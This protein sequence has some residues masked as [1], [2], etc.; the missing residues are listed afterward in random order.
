MK[1]TLPGGASR[2]P[3]AIYQ[4]CLERQEVRVDPHQQRVVDQLDDLWRALESKRA[5]GLFSAWRRRARVQGIYLWGG[6]GRGK[7]WLMDLFLESLSTTR[8]RRAHFHRFMA[9]VHQ[10]LNQ[11]SNARDPLSLIARQWSDDCDVLCFDE[12]YVSDI[13]D[14]M[15]LGNLLEKLFA[16]G[17]VLVAT[18]N[19]RPDDLYRG[20]LQRSRFLPA[21]ECI[22]QHCRVIELPG[23]RD[24]RLRLLERAGVYQIRESQDRSRAMSHRFEQFSAGEDLANVFEINGRSF[25]AR[26]R[27]LNVAW[28]DFDELCVK[29]RGVVDYIE[30]ARSFNTLLVSGVPVMD[31]AG[32]DMARRFISLVDE[33]YDRNVKLVISAA[34]QPGDLYRGER[35]EFEYERT[36]S[37]LTEMQGQ[38]YLARPH[39]P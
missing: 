19:V 5:R 37:R 2:S 11:H 6:V 25:T 27:G 12:F 36:S 14:A 7:T 39:R 35:L 4:Q 31:D 32:A 20:G 28:F 9:H 21:I 22:K 29:A 33:L 23:D 18:S 38:E 16:A 17:I 34:A 30:I 1:T 13:A 10:G 8:K 15:L 3:L 26:R 24:Y